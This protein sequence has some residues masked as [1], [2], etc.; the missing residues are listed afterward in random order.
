VLSTLRTRFCETHSIYTYCGIVLVAMNPYESLPLY[1]S[2]MINAYNGKNMGELDPHIFA[3][4]EEAFKCMARHKRNQSI[5]VS[6][7][8]GA[9]KT[10]SAKYAMRYFATVGGAEAETQIEK[11]VLAS[12]PIMEAIGNAKTI[13]N[14]NS[15][16]VCVCVCNMCVI[17]SFLFPCPLHSRFGK[18]I[19][20]MFNPYQHIV[21]ANM[22]TYLLEKSRVVFQ[23]KGERNYHIFYQLCACADQKEFEE[24]ELAE[25][26]EFVFT[27][28]GSSIQGGSIQG[29]SIQGSSI[30][31]DGVDDAQCF[32]ETRHALSLLGVSDEYQRQIFRVLAAILHMGNIA[33]TSRTKR[34]E[35]ARISDDDTH[36]SGM[37]ALFCECLE[38]A[39]THTNLS[40]SLSIVAS[41]RQP[42]RRRCGDAEQ[43]DHAQ[44][45]PDRQG[46]IQQA[47]D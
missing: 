32:Q 37:H 6:G 42:P 27:N 29:S 14:D 35:D 34:N 10:V 24:L 21:G 26:D 40:H 4:A 12:N 17:H 41:N 5:I 45:D 46:D 15:R 43:V 38:S 36:L 8:S 7:E 3:V 11:K 18:Y 31:I 30:R 22:C 9:G 33:I 1:T 23:A 39:H 28:Q 13:R 44:E 47:A 25:A 2:E 20:I 19:E 16:C